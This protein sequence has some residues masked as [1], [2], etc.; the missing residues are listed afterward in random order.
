MLLEYGRTIEDRLLFYD[1]NIVLEISIT[2]EIAE[3][4][5]NDKRRLSAN[6]RVC[7]SGYVTPESSPWC[8][9]QQAQGKLNDIPL[10]RAR[11]M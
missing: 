4:H 9:G 7:I 10:V 2:W 6:A 1:V 11:D 5:Q 8:K 3:M